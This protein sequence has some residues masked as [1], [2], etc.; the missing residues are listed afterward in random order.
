MH[1]FMVAGGPGIQKLTDLQPIQQIDIYPLVCALLGYDKPN[2]IDGRVD[3]VVHL[4]SHKPS[5]QFLTT[6]RQYESKPIPDK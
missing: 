3:N 6:F 2:A 5:E 1:S 4:M